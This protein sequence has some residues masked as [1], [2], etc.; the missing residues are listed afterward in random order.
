MT[1]GQGSIC[2]LPLLMTCLAKRLCRRNRPASQKS[3]ERAEGKSI[4]VTVWR[5]SIVE[6]H[7]HEFRSGVR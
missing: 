6:A 5:H 2:R 4:H 1:C 7:C 3:Q